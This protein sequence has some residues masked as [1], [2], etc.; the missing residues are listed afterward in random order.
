MTS[1]IHLVSNILQFYGFIHLF[2]Q[3]VFTEDYYQVSFPSVSM[4]KNVPDNAGHTGSIPGLG[5]SPG[6]ENGHLLQCSCLGYPV[7]RGV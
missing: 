7:D 4:V 3:N 1:E 2:I 6:E 5:K